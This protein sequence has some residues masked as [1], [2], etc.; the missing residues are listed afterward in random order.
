MYTA[1]H[2]LDAGERIKGP[3]Y[4]KPV[5]V[6]DNVW[7]G[8]RAV[9]NPGVSVGDNAVVA[10]GAVVTEDVPDDVVVRGNPASVV[11]DLETDG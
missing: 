1:T 6:G 10:S 7:I 9:L 4:G 2:P 5:T 3:E 11:K 8:G